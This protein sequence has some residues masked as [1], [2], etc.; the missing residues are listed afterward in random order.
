MESVGLIDESRLRAL[1]GPAYARGL[2]YLRDG[3]VKSCTVVGDTIEGEV[4]G[5]ETYRVKVSFAGGQLD[6][7]CTCPVLYEVCKHA[8]ALALHHLGER[9]VD[10]PAAEGTF[11][12]KADV[13]AFVIEHRIEHALLLSAELLIPRIDLPMHEYWVRGLLARLALRDLASLEGAARHARTRDLDGGLARAAYDLLHEQA[14]IVREA[15]AEEEIRLVTPASVAPLW[16]KLVDVRRKL[17]DVASPRSRAWR[18]GQ[19]WSFDAASATITWKERE[20]I[21]RPRDFMTQAI[22]AR[23]TIPGGG[24]PKLECTCAQTAC[25][26]G[27]S[28][29]DATLDVLADPD[30]APLAKQMLDELLKPA[31]SR[32][33][34]ELDRIEERATKPRIA[35]E[36][37]WHIEYELGAL[38]LTPTVK[39]QMKR[40]GMSSGQRT[41]P[42]RMLEEHG[43]ALSEGD[44]RIAELLTAWMPGRGSTYPA[45][46]FAALA[47][48]P[49]VI[50]EHDDEPID[51]VRTELG[52]TALGEGDKIRV[53][54]SL[55]GA[56]MSPRLLV[57][58]LQLHPAGEP[59][60]VPEPEKRRCVMVDVTDDARALWA[61]LDK[62][63]DAFPPEAHAALLER[64]GKLESRLPIDV[65]E[66]LKG[67]AVAPDPTV[68]VRVRLLPDVTL[69]AELFVRPGPGAPLFAPGAGPRDVMVPVGTDG[70]GYIRR[71]LGTELPFARSMFARLPI[72]DAE[73]G[74]PQCFRFADPDAAIAFVD[75][76]QSPPS[77]IEAE[78]VDRRKPPTVSRAAPERL[79]VY[80]DKKR[81]WFGI[82][83]DLKIEAGRLELAVILDAARR[84]QRYVRVDENRWVE[85]SQTLRERLQAVAD[86]TFAAARTKDALELSPS[87]VLAIR[88]LAESGV[89]VEVAA[90]WRELTQ[91]VL[92]AASFKPKRPRGLTGIL[93]D[94]QIDGHA[95][96]ARLASWGA[97]GCLADDMGL[98]KTIQAIALLLDRKQLGPALVL[99]PTSVA[100]NWAR[101]LE[102]FAPSLN[103]VMY[104][105]ERTASLAKLEPGDVV[106][107]SYGLLVRDAPQLAATKFATLV[108]DEAQ[109]LK[110]PTTQRAKAAR[111]LNADFRI[112]LTG[113][114]LEN[115]LGELWSLFSVVFPGLLGSWDQFRERFAAPIEKVKDPEARAA[116][117][118]VI[119][120]FLLRRTKAEV[121]RELPSRTEVEVPV[122]LSDDEHQLYEDARL[123][124][125]AELTIKG[126]GMRDEQ[127]RFQVLAALTRLRLL[128]SHPK[129]YDSASTIAS[130]KLKRTIE[131]LDELRSEGHRALVFSQFTS[132][133]SLVREALDA[134]GF[135]TLYLDGA[136]PAKDR[137]ALIDR[138]Q[139]GEGDAFLISLK[140]GGTGINLTAADYVIHL[141]PWWNPAVEDQA[142][143]RAHRIG[144]T[145]P[146][147]VYRLISRGTIEDKI[148]ALHRDKRALVAGVLEGT[149]VAARL[150]AKDLMSLLSD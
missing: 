117:A 79:R 134:H 124:A 140:A 15:V 84:Q 18:G 27:L 50:S 61:A 30:K 66:N 129:L 8:V 81:D 136:T 114:P 111:S 132:H 25:V 34:A 92:A 123:S 147:T 137:A 12:T 56:R 42:H 135:S 130:S 128:A 26:H 91:R 70:R 116:L 127:R 2:A 88:A 49:R 32:A 71:E 149:D 31:W 108:V 99:A 144:Q 122:A 1:A 141:D 19:T 58:L 59:L 73:E 14:A 68:V 94:Y 60:F 146:V 87:A 57:S 106:I 104:T 78:W 118:R 33:L 76:L 54:P 72:V 85:L 126:G 52:F 145:K 63:G 39:K 131:L 133:L 109:A 16:T 3:A 46:A 69:E 139:A 10:V 89:H 7:S 86:R 112:A 9:P 4:V 40:G 5:G 41:S 55:F 38:S 80:V 64:L 17:R 120:P 53:E 22:T 28:A 101:E 65:S 95:W 67:R 77:G 75:A 23:L 150:T 107:A 51:L 21:C 115:H 103:P 110:N 44:R 13:D 48:H 35:I 100:F 47:G 82:A 102:R 125:V 36:V 121:A 11:P 113:T 143:D 96:L 62:H 20:R 98:G 105:E 37:W 45:R 119:Q 148:V 97:G 74:P 83:G 142:T 24:T 138:F 43:D 6:A 90:P 29:V 93:R